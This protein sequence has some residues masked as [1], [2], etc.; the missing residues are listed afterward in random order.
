MHNVV[1][2]DPQHPGESTIATPQGDLYLSIV[3]PCYNEQKRLPDTLRRV[4][5]FLRSRPYPAEVVV[6]DD[7]S[8][9]DTAALVEQA[10]R[11]DPSI[12]LIKNE[13]RGKAYAVRTGML[14]AEGRNVLFTDADGATPITEVDKLLALLEAGADVAIASRE[15]AGARRIGDPGHRHVM[16]RVFNLI[17]RIIA[18]PGIHEKK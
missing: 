15:G 5:E 12:R 13:H 2:A 14:A 17:V 10:M 6:V 16:G 1:G 11:Q 4:G 8:S 18:L 9:D 7:G 3:L